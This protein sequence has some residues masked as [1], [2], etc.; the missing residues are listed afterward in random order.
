MN[1]KILPKQAG[2][3]LI[4]LLV[5]MAIALIVLAGVVNTVV[6]SKSSYINDEQ[7]AYIQEN[8]RFV[9]DYLGREI[10]QAGYSGGCSRSGA[11]LA[12]SIDPQ[13]TQGDYLSSLMPVEGFEGGVDVFPGSFSANIWSA[14]ST[15][16]AFIVRYSDSDGELTVTNHNPPQSA[17]ID[18]SSN[19]SL[20]DGDILMIA[21]EDCTQLG[22]FA[23]TMTPST[24]RVQHNPGSGG[25]SNNCTKRLGGNFDC[26]GGSSSW[27]E[28]PPGS[29]VLRMV[30]QAF[31]IGPSSYDANTPSL[32]VQG[33]GSAGAVVR[34]ELIS[35]VE[36][37]QVVYGVDNDPSQDGKAN[38][39]YPANLIDDD[40]A[41]STNSYIAWDRV[42][43]MRLQLV[44]RSREQMLE[45]N[46]AVTLLGVNYN[47]RYMRQVISTTVQLRNVALP[48]NTYN[49]SS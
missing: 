19:H 11:K 9:L 16:D 28:Y 3:S 20:V 48:A 8:S 5:S 22:V 18:V 30:A 47:D 35:G 38:R 21:S 10:R 15:P 39:Y 34:N 49:V 36:D 46:R 6:L 7:I 17:I 37:M 43:S 40:P 14:T 31:Y 12:N 27:Y 24:I 33:I 2:L 4:E 1:G 25:S 42:V 29:S 44:V 26:S 41:D 23:V 13:S 45:N 32:F